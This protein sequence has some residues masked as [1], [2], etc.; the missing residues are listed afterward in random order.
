MTYIHATHAP[1][2]PDHYTGRT[3]PFESDRAVYWHHA[4]QAFDAQP[5]ALVGFACHQGVRRNQGR[6]GAKSAPPIIKEFFAKSPITADV[7][8]AYADLSSLV[9]DCGDVV[10]HD[11]DTIIKGSLESAQN[12]YATYITD[13]LQKNALAIG[14]GG[15]HEIAYGS[16]LGLYKYLQTNVKSLAKIG[17]INFDAHFDLRTDEYAT[18]GT[19]FLQIAEMIDDVFYYFCVGINRFANTA[20]LF[21]KAHALGVG[22]IS[23]D[24]CHRLAY[25]EIWARLDDFVKSVD[26]LYITVDLDCLSAG[27]MPALSAVNAKGIE[28]DLVEFLLE[29][30]IQTGKVKVLDFAEFNPT[31]DIDN[32]G[33]KT[34]ARL[35][36]VCVETY[37]LK[38]VLPLK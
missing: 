14:L 15:G 3:D 6:V 19:P 35:L 31:Y 5:I 25:D 27:V 18:S 33:A 16:F 37:L 30:L 24:D 8:N 4:V 1:F 9:G 28:L 11:N 17:I 7:Q 26:V 32:R 21:D 36:L 10:C 29:K 20:S 13:A 2:N 23:D 34:V 38:R 22:V 12:Q